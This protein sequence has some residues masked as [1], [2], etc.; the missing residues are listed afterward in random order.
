MLDADVAAVIAAAAEAGGLVLV[1]PRGDAIALRGVVNT[2]LQL[3]DSAEPDSPNVL[4]ADHLVP[5][6]DGDIRVRWYTSKR[7][8]AGSAVVYCHGGGR[9]CGSVDLYDR[10]VS[11]YVEETVIPFLSV[12]YRL[13]PECAGTTAVDDGF[14]ALAWFV[15]RADKFGVDKARIAIMGDSGGGGVAA[16]VAIAARDAGIPVAKQILIYPMLDDR[17]IEPDPEIAPFATWT[18]DN[19]YTGWNAL[20][21][22]A[23][24]KR[25]RSFAHRAL[26]ANRVRRSRACLHRR[27]RAR[28]LP[29]REHPLRAQP[30]P[31]WRVHRVVCP[32]R[33]PARLRSRRA[34]RRSVSMLLGR[35]VPRDQSRVTK[36]VAQRRDPRHGRNLYRG[37]PPL[38][39]MAC[40]VS[41]AAAGCT[42][43]VRTDREVVGGRHT[44]VSLLG[45]LGGQFPAETVGGDAFGRGGAVDQRRREGV[46]ADPVRHFHGGDR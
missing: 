22:A 19:N 20:L 43:H 40:P 2:T 36:S 16:G 31:R 32:P 46:G 27:G 7:L 38:T 29:R 30:G 10:L 25:Q 42:E 26:A 28:Y 18:Y 1:T 6:A 3:M 5:V 12:D 17:N 14:A 37:N 34:R 33:L 45:S 9:V 41:R 13:A 8:A 15:E 24:G 11:K 35:P 23:P 44:D 21:G 39:L 4:T